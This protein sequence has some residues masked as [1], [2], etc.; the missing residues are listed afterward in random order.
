VQVDEKN[1][2]DGGCTCRV[3]EKTARMEVARAGW[4]KFMVCLWRWTDVVRANG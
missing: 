2:K 4:M 1:G 3:D